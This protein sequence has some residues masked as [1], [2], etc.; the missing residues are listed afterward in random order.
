MAKK[1]NKWIQKVGMKKGA[2]SKQLGIPEKEDIPMTLLNTIVAATPGDTIKNPTKTGKPKYKVTRLMERR[3]ILAR[4][5]KNISK[6][7]KK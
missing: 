6:R 2:L 3:S 1:I 5:F 7:N 4:N